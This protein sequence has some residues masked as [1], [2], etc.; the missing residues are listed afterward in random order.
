MFERL[1]IWKHESLVLRYIKHVYVDPEKAEKQTASDETGHSAV[2]SRHS[3]EQ[4][5][6]GPQNDTS[7]SPQIL[8]SDRASANA[9]EVRYSPPRPS[10]DAYDPVIVSKALKNCRTDESVQE[11]LS[12]LTN[13]TF[14][15]MLMWHI[16]EKQLWETA[17]YKAALMDRRLFSKIISNTEYKPSKDTAIALVFALRLSMTEAKD[18]LERAGYTL[19]HSI[20]RDIILEYFIGEG[21]YDLYKINAFLYGM[22]EKTVGRSE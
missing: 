13:L 17:V 2:D 9:T 1:F 15:Q 18:L 3:Q 10:Y 14:S 20:R 22:N 19:S 16:R 4:T 8:Y 7:A 12:Q 11:R 6:N 21:V 5:E